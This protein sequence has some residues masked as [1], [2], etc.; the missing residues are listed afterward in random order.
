MTGAQGRI[1]GE[2]SWPGSPLDFE[3]TSL[4]GRL[5][6]SLGE[7][8]FL[9]A[10]PGAARLFGVLSLQAL[11]RRLLLD[12]SD[13]FQ[14][15]LEFDSIGGDIELQNGVARTDNLRVLGLQVGVLVEGSAD[16]AQQTQDLRIVAVPELNTTTATL[17]WAALNPAVGIGAFIA[18]LLLREPMTAAATREFHVTG[19]WGAPVVQRV[20]TPVPVAGSPASA[21]PANSAPPT[22]RAP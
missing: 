16:L 12:F 4:R 21:A 1:D 15:G 17:A 11:P 18:Q 19:P 8:R 9:N 14:Q 2:L 10:E 5:A 3:L 7:G 6:V 22:S 20:T 13:V